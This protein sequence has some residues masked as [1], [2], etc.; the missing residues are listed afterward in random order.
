MA[1]EI[2]PLS[3]VSIIAFAVMVGG[4]IFS[5]IKKTL[6]TYALIITNFIVFVI[7]LVFRTTIIYELGFRPVYL[8][9]ELFPQIYTL[10]TSMFVH[11]DFLHIFGNM[12]IFFFIGMAFEQRIGWNKFLIIYLITGVGGALTH[13]IL[14]LGS[15]IPLVGASGAIFGIMGAFAFS[16][17]NDEVVMPIPLGFIMIFRRI[18]VVYAVLIFAAIETVIVFVGTQDS[19]AHFAHIGGLLTG[20]I[21]AALILRRQ[22]SPSSTSYSYSSGSQPYTVNV[23]H[24]PR[25]PYD[26]SKLAPLAN[27]SNLQQL[28]NK[29]Q[30]ETV[31]QVQ[32]VWMEHFIEKAS[33]PV[34]QHQLNHFNRKIWCDHCNYSITY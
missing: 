17:P 25:R 13:S 34:C 26:F 21:L 30:V 7:T 20:V 27:T 31:P 24:Q 5:Y 2:L 33:C 14:D 8:T 4:I 9:P 15:I 19:T 28:L 11:S 10:F 12:L 29:V 3:P 6:M 22:P 18:R 23:Q 1:I 32:D 16:Y